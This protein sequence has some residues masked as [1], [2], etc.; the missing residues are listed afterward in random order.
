MTMRGPDFGTR[1]EREARERRPA[2]AAR[3]ETLIDTART[4]KG[5]K[6]Q[7]ALVCLCIRYT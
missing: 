6:K 3:C 4:E 5:A 7:V 2:L 1:L